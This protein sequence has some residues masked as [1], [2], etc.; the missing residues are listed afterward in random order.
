MADVIGVYC[1][2]WV[3]TNTFTQTIMSAISQKGLWRPADNC[4]T[5]YQ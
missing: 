1:F 3:Y 2:V 4:H 5:I